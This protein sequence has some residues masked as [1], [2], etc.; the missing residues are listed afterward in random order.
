MSERIFS[1]MLDDK[2]NK[3]M[4]Y[5]CYKHEVKIKDFVKTCIIEALITRGIKICIKEK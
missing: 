5:Y 3:T 2:L 1:V 4:K